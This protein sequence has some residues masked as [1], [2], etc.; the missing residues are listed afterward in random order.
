[1]SLDLLAYVAV[2]AL[3]GVLVLALDAHMAQ[4][5]TIRALGPMRWASL[6]KHGRKCAVRLCRSLL[7]QA[8]A[9][10]AIPDDYAHDQLR[11]WYQAKAQQSQPSTH[12]ES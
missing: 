10:G 8:P 2:S 11:A 7:I 1:M 12:K 6:T 9:L 5:D 4:R 3:A